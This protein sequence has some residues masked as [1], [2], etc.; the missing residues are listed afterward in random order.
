[1]N[2]L[3][4]IILDSCRFDSFERASTPNFDRIGPLEKRF[5]YASWTSPSHF[6][7]LMGQMPHSNEEGKPASEVYREDY[8]K[9]SDRLGMDQKTM[10]EDFVPSLSLPAYLKGLK[11]ETRALVSMPVLHPATG[12]SR[13]FDH[14]EL[15]SSEEGCSDIF[16]SLHFSERNPC[17]Y[18]LNL[19]ETHY[20]Y[21]LD[22]VPHLHGLHGVVKGLQREKGDG[23]VDS[24][25]F[26]PEDLKRMHQSQIQA[27][28]RI[29]EEFGKLL[30][31]LPRGCHLIVTSD[32]GECF[33][34]GNFFGHGPTTDPK[35][36]EV[37][38]L[39]GKFL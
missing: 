17:F 24:S 7:M 25:A 30:G 36:F 8:A 9:W 26:S 35:V 18:L 21:L 1:M 23:G 16:N 15:L 37:P 27:V 28:E 2:H 4:L 11:Y 3:L 6:A 14:Y 13:H 19:K 38:F 32:H 5:S 31:N 20:P 22:D 12:L 33:G 39:E 29:D 34:E 10:L